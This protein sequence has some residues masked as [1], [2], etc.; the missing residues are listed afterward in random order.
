ML[1]MF[2][3]DLFSGSIFESS[4]QTMQKSKQRHPLT[5]SNSAIPTQPMFDTFHSSLPTQMTRAEALAHALPFEDEEPGDNSGIRQPVNHLQTNT[6][7]SRKRRK[8]NEF[9][10]MD[11]IPVS[12]SL[13][14]EIKTEGH[15]PQ[16]PHTS[17]FPEDSA[18]FDV[19]PKSQQFKKR[20]PNQRTNVRAKMLWTDDE[21][22][23]LIKGVNL[24]GYGRWKKVLNHPDL[25]FL[26]ERT[27][28]DLKDRYV[29]LHNN[30][31]HIMRLIVN[32]DIG[33]VSTTAGQQTRPESPCLLVRD[34]E[35]P[36]PV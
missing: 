29:L 16:Q 15:V 18:E 26:D 8:F 23:D 1:S 36:T 2:S 27:S 28:V 6:D 32:L 24:V 9:R 35:N 21:T 20:R 12:R 13:T 25:K 11:Y 22:A 5:P 34:A 4:L 10:E 30:F 17:S 14:P 19:K 3:H 31:W 33:H 7:G